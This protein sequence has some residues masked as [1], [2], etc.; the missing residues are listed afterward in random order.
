MVYF[1]ILF[2]NSVA[3]NATLKDH[4]DFLNELNLMKK[5]K[6]HCHVVQLLGYCTFEGTILVQFCVT[7]CNAKYCDAALPSTFPGEQLEN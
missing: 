6:P 2:Q 4:K 3:E 5:L 7:S 1:D